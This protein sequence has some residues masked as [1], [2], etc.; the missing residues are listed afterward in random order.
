MYGHI[1][2]MLCVNDISYKISSIVATFSKEENRCVFE[3]WLFWL[4]DIGSL[5]V[6]NICRLGYVRIYLNVCGKY[7]FN[8]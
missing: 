1:Y 6:F 2:N 5:A 3:I 8:A 4:A 7:F